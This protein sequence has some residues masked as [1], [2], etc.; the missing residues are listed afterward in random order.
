MSQLHQGA[1]V[2]ARAVQPAP[3]AADQGREGWQGMSIHPHLGTARS[4][5][6]EDGACES[7]CQ[8]AE[9]STD[10]NSATAV[11]ILSTGLLLRD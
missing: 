10:G 6:R 11:P 3:P 5:K 9:P 4:Q 1:A 8:E 2:V 7:A